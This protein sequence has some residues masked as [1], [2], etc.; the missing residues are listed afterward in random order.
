[1]YANSAVSNPLRALPLLFQELYLQYVRVV[2]DPLLAF[3]PEERNSI[4]EKRSP[5]NLSV[6]AIGFSQSPENE[7]YGDDPN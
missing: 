3:P 1:M 7:P 6:S 5:L 4:K 2:D